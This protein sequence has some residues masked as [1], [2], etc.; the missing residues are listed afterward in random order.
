MLFYLQRIKDMTHKIQHQKGCKTAI[1]AA[2]M[3]KALVRNEDCI[4][5]E[6]DSMKILKG[7]FMKFNELTSQFPWKYKLTRI[8]AVNST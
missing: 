1:L 7:L 6:L 8:Y 5:S 4:D 2:I 3:Q